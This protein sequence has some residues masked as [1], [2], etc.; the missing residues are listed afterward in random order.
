M[1]EIGEKLN[2]PPWAQATLA[3]L[4]EVNFESALDGSSADISELGTQFETA[5][6]QST[7]GGPEARVYTMLAS[8][9]GL[10]FQPDNPNAPFSP[11][12]VFGDRRS[13]DLSDFRGDSAEVLAKAEAISKNIVLK[14][15]LAD[16]V[17]TLERKRG[18]LGLDAVGL[19]LDI[20]KGI[21]AGTLKLRFEDNQGALDHYSYELLRRSLQ[22]G[23]LVGW[24]K[25]KVIDARCYVSTLMQRA[26][27]EGVA[28]A[29]LWFGG[30]DLEFRTSDPQDVA[31][32]IESLISNLTNEG[33]RIHT[34]VELWRLAA[35][36]YLFARDD[37]AR[38]RCQ[39]EAAECLA[40]EG[41]KIF[42]AGGSAM[43]AAHSVGSAIAQLSGVPNKKERRAELRHKL[44]DIQSRVSEEMSEF[45]Q[46]MDIR[47]LVERTEHAFE[48]LSLRDQLFLLAD[49]PRSP[50]PKGLVAGAKEAI[51][52]HPLSSL[53]ET[54]HMDDE[55]KVIHRSGGAAFGNQEDT[56]AIKQQI[57]QTEAIRRGIIITSRFEP[58]R[59]IIARQHLLSE[60][61]IE[62]LMRI[63][64]FVPPDLVATYS[65]GFAKLFQGDYVSACY[66]LTPLLENSL[67][68]VLKNEGH[69]VTIFDD[70]T[71]T[72][73]D[74]TISSL[75]DQMRPELDRIFTEAI[76]TD[77][78]G[79]F[80]N[81]PGPHL[82]HQLA[83][84]L[85]HDGTP[86]GPDA[87][88]GCW[89]IFRL[90]L[91]PLMNERTNIE[92][93]E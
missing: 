72:Q 58:A 88:Y 79:L 29:L 47:D 67:R 61:T 83:H 53:F 33:T 50:D 78:D 66:V 28:G 89:L 35:R 24:D 22:I 36:A 38:N 56:S 17:W 64:P 8:V 55:G 60:D 34:K 7:D 74:R 80:L 23:K 76:T 70:A 43:I 10:H 84:G 57:A 32:A 90:C 15:R 4:G 40:A 81:K 9:C 41:F 91:V 42:E 30:L 85:F 92:I 39:V 71:K 93:P 52:D 44:I 37:D 18:Q 6:K 11:L 62:P 46:E 3:D 1:S 69:D 21:D 63:S 12:F 86:Y 27:K 5:A 59:R 26:S 75:F 31:T 82:R 49:L 77:I 65:K 20:V 54:S 51:H 13:A 14:A 87:I 48:R 73:E 45:S 68:Y 25:D 2:Q 16:V 19:Y